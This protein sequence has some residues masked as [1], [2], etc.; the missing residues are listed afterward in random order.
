LF[1]GYRGL[2]PPPRRKTSDVRCRRE[3]CEI[4]PGRAEGD[5]FK[6]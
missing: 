3:A 5:K 2:D 6:R 1:G 4:D